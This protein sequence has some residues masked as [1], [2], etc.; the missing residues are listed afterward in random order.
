MTLRFLG[1][2]IAI[3]FAPMR[4]STQEIDEKLDKRIARLDEKL[5]ASLADLAR[6]HDADK[7]PEAAHFFASCAVGFGSK[8]PRQLPGGVGPLGPEAAL[9]RLRRVPP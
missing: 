9:V 1:A 3:I 8:E 7:N 4:V 5:L 6:K 2:A